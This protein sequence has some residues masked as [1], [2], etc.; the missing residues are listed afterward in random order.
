MYYTYEVRMAQ[1]ISKAG[2][3]SNFVAENL[4]NL[5]TRKGYLSELDTDNV[6]VVSNIIAVEKI[7]V[8]ICGKL[9]SPGVTMSGGVTRAGE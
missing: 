4:H 3:N 8:R 5:S 1:Q 2:K 7:K 9:N 6:W